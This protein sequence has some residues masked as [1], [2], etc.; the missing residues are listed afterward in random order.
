MLQRNK[1]GKVTGKIL[2]DGRD[3]GSAFK[4]MTGYVFQDDMLMST[5]TV[6][7]ALMFSAELRLP[8]AMPKHEKEQRVEN[9]MADLGISHIADRRIGDAMSRGISGGEKRR[10][11]I[12]MELVVSPHVLFLDEVFVESVHQINSHVAN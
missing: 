1:V 4:R 3:V 12:G 11:S 7:E 10:V 8:D 2:I 5:M 9:V 6:R